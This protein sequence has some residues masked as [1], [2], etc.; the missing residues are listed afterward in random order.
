MAGKRKLDGLAWSILFG[1]LA[2]SVITIVLS[3]LIALFISS[4]YFDINIRYIASMIIQLIAALIGA[5]TTGKISN[6][7]KQI[8]SVCTV[9]IYCFILLS[10]A[11]LFFDGIASH[12]WAVLLSGGVGCISAIL[13]NNSRKRPGYRKKKVRHYR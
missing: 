6:D 11:I 10:A 5:Y 3:M 7:R 13:L 8:A 2:S 4:E 1:V 9:A 12:F